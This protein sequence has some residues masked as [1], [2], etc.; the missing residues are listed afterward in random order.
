MNKTEDIFRHAMP[1][2]KPGSGDI[3]WFARQNSFE[4]EELNHLVAYK[5]KTLK[6]LEDGRYSKKPDYSYPH[7]LPDGLLD[8]VFY[9]GMA[10]AILDYLRN[11]GIQQHTELLNLKSSQA[12][13]LN[14]LF[15]LRM[16]PDLAANVLRPFLSGL[17][18][19]TDIQFEYTA[20]DETNGE[21]G[22]TE[23]LGEPPGGKRGQNRTSIDAAIFW[24]DVNNDK[25]ITLVEW[26]YTERSFG[27]CS[28][29]DKALKV[30]K[31]NCQSSSFIKS[32]LLVNNGPHRSR[33][34]W[35]HL[36]ESGI[37]LGRMECVV[38]CP[39]RGPFY[40]LMRQ[41][42]VAQ[43]LRK[44]NANTIVDV[45]AVHFRKNE[46]LHAVPKEI[47]P[48]CQSTKSDVIDAWNA[49]LV[50]V[51]KLRTIDVEDIMAKYDADSSIDLKWRAFIRQRY[52]I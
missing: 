25:H 32:C 49:T 35:A 16:K 26:K 42:L 47:Q 20:Q 45:V 4:Q 9:E 14:F 43:Y 46:A 33:H 8:K 22:C 2:D 36:K 41:F 29:Y 51:P 1:D 19:V 38:G 52:R 7:I 15:P 39:F 31:L 30:D 21:F 40:Q 13:C 48:L 3:H 24:T 34:Y 50:G 6:I 5:R 27:S 18:T 37:E 12:A 11:E 10:T 23:W 17:K 28:A 44:K